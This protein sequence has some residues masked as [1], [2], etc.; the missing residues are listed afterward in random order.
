MKIHQKLFVGATALA[1]FGLS[2]CQTVSISNPGNGGASSGWSHNSGGNALYRG[3]L[4]AYDLLGIADT[5]DV[6]EAQ[7]QAALGRGK[8]GVSVPQN[9]RI[10]LV[11][12]GAQQPDGALK[13][14]FDPYFDVHPFS[15]IPSVNKTNHYR[16]NEKFDPKSEARRLRLA[17]AQAGASHIVCVWGTLE[18][19]EGHTPGEAVSWVP[20]GGQF[21]PDKNRKTR[22]NLKAIV[23]DVATGNWRSFS[24][25]PVVRGYVS[26]PMNRSAAWDRQVDTLKS[27]AYPKL[28]AAVKQS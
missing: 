19:S 11:Q 15:G 23:L 20:V 12:S 3:E 13:D 2:S 10:M 28:A 4:H 1:F 5:E 27:E 16:S 9:S 24:P 26:A 8:S 6:T 21:V 25:E 18:T 17:A 14:A 22:I 7:I